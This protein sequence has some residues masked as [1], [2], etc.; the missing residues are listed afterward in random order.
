MS[1]NSTVSAAPVY[2]PKHTYG[3]SYNP[4]ARY[5]AAFWTGENGLLWLFG[6]EESPANLLSDLWPFNAS[7]LEWAYM[8]GSSAINRPGRYGTPGLGNASNT[9]RARFGPCSWMDAEGNRWLFGALGYGN[10][11][12]Y[13][14]Y[15]N[16]LWVCNVQS[17][18]WIFMSGNATSRNP[19]A[20]GTFG[21]LPPSN[22]PG[23]RYYCMRF[24]D[25]LWNLQLFGGFGK[26]NSASG[27]GYLKDLWVYDVMQ[28]Q[29]AWISGSTEAIPLA[30]YGTFQLTGSTM[31]LAL[32]TASPFGE[33]T[34]MTQFRL[35]GSDTRTHQERGIRM[36]SSHR[37]R[38]CQLR[39]LQIHRRQR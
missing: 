25:V 1:G 35:E 34:S 14:G 3:P 13:F 32:V 36:M 37:L 16:D 7:S 26:T 22:H 38:C 12:D 2:G 27:S 6:G 29:W 23:G 31:C 19:G 4:G 15:W 9:P 5:G 21:V 11:T 39:H 28:R 30:H 8:G 10:G 33:S 18:V 24:V 20:Y 17:S